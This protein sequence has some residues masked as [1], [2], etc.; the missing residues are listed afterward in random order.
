[1]ECLGIQRDFQILVDF[2]EAVVEIQ[3]FLQ[4]LAG[5]DFGILETVL[6][7]GASVV[8]VQ[9]IPAFLLLGLRQIPFHEK[10]LIELLCQAVRRKNFYPI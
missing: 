6:A 3:D 7:P 8:A 1:M 9:K 10:C 2:L 5:F 4:N